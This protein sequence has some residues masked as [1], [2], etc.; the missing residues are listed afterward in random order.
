MLTSMMVAGFGGQGVM[1]IGKLIGE[2]AFDQGLHVT[3]LPSY[4]P[5]QRG[6]TANCT[7]VQS[8]RPIGSPVS[9]ELDVLCVM[10]QPSLTKFIDNVRPGGILMTNSS[11]VDVSGVTRKDIKIVEVDADNLAYQLGNRKIA[12]VIIFATYMEIAKTMPID[13]VKSIA[14]K[15]L[16]KK[17]ELL[18]MNSKAFDAG[19][20]ISRK[21][22]GA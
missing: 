16:G 4:G 17:P 10:N 13:V 19:V 12:N 6:G 5:E 8:D 21:A 1:L 20:E 14:M 11:L 22:L 9:T 7:V 3:F 18:E 2:C 15:I